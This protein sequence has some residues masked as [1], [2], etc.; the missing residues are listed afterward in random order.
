MIRE[1]ELETGKLELE[2]D[3]E[4]DELFGFASRKNNKRGFLFLSKVLGKHYPS[5]PLIMKE[6]H[7]NLSKLIKPKLKIGPTVVIGF[8]ETA[9]CLGY[10]IYESLGLK[11][12]FY[13]NSTRHQINHP[14]FLTF[15]ESH[16]HAVSHY[17]Y[18]PSSKK[19]RKILQNAVNIVLVDDEYTTGN[20]LK[21]IIKSLKKQNLNANF[22]AVG[23]LDWTN[24][25]IS[26]GI[27]DIVSIVNGSFSFS[28]NIN[29]ESSNYLS[30]LKLPIIHNN[31]I[32]SFGRVGCEKIAIDFATIVKDLPKNNEKVLV[33]GTGEFMN[34]AYCL[35]LFLKLYSNNVY[36]QSTTRSPI[37]IGNDVKTVIAFKD[38]Y[39]ENIDNFLY[40]FLDHN[41]SKVYICYETLN[42][43][44]EHNL[45]H[46]IKKYVKD[47]YELFF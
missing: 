37:M 11:D 22:I 12:S 42:I 29:F 6:V 16:S 32:N 47:V 2:Y 21:N 24:K 3:S 4:F 31:L 39:S 34:V 41:Y 5:C 17:L 44:T 8:A 33:L 36:V 7:D 25:S 38:N 18:L 9:T 26:N 30:E 15:N 35:A 27:P 40:N 1:I 13:L 28:N 14:L 20:T 10:G 19:H 43:P 45:Y 23:I 46:Q